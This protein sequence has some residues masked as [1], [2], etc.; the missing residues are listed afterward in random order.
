[1]RSKSSMGFRK[2]VFYG[3]W[4]CKI[5]LFPAIGPQHHIRAILNMK[6]L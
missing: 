4:R 5:D 1:M 3:K 6:S 2:A